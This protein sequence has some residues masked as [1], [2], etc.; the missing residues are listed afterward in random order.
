MLLIENLL[1]NMVTFRNKGTQI[2][3]FYLKLENSRLSY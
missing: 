3:E 2:V 1:E